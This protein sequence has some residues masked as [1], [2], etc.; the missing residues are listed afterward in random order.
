MNKLKNEIKYY[1]FISIIY[2][3]AR[4][5]MK[6]IV[7]A[8]SLSLYIFNFNI[9]VTPQIA[10]IFILQI[11]IGLQGL[12]IILKSSFACGCNFTQRLWIVIA[13]LFLNFYI[14]CFF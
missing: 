9:L 1:I 13:E 5:I 8:K 2:Q 4:K 12:H 3:N 6:I 10:H 11:H 7:V 14:A